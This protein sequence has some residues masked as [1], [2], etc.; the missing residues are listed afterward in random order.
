MNTRNTRIMKTEKGTIKITDRVYVM[1]EAK[2]PDV[3]NYVFIED[4]TIKNLFI[5]EDYT[6]DHEA[7]QKATEPIPVGNLFDWN[8]LLPGQ[9]KKL[10]NILKWLGVYYWN[11]TNYMGDLIQVSSGQQA[12]FTVKDGEAILTKIL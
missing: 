5:S 4:K 2:K 11:R 12:E 8:P 10:P 1:R 7:Y 6:K 9:H 3:K